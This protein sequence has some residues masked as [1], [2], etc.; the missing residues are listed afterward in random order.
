MPGTSLDGAGLPDWP[1][2]AGAGCPAWPTLG[3]VGRGRDRQRISELL[4]AYAERIDAGDFAG[5]ADLFAEG[6][7]TVD[8][9]DRPR[10]G[11]DG[12]LA[13]YEASTRR[14]PDGTPRTK[15]VTTNVVVEL[16]RGATSA[17]AR[18]YYTVLQAVPGALT[19]QPVIAGRYRD[20][21]ARG[22]DGWHFARRHI[23]VDLVGDLGHHLLFHLPTE[24]LH[25]R[26]TSARR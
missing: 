4:Y 2:L 8:G 5:V 1:M 9:D 21:F 13:M 22:D 7:I 16:G 10:R 15:H 25:G 12:V 11:R 26:G 24:G 23:V 17:T 19:L 14:Y 18:S 20:R 6:E 3:G